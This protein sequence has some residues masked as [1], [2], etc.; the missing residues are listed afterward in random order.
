MHAFRLAHGKRR[1]VDV[2]ALHIELVVYRARA[3]SGT[4]VTHTDY[5]TVVIGHGLSERAVRR[6]IRQAQQDGWTMT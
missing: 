6:N 3:G 5:S 4:A 1:M 2:A